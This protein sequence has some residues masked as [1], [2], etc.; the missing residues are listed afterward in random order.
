MKI[1]E[2]KIWSRKEQLKYILLVLIGIEYGDISPRISETPED[3]RIL[4]NDMSHRM[5]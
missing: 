4:A 5:K 2:D 1:T 3:I